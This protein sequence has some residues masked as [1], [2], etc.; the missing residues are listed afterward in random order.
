MDKE[1][2]RG[3]YERTWVRG[4]T[5]GSVAAPQLH[6]LSGT[7]GLR[8]VFVPSTHLSCYTFSYLFHPMLFFS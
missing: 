8:K 5:T 7:T 2:D 6:L 4:L 1:M 3:R